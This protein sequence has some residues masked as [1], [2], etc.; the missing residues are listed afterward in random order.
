MPPDDVHLD[1]D[2]RARIARLEAELSRLIEGRD[3]AADGDE[4]SDGHHHPAEAA[5]DAEY[6]EK[7]LRDRLRLSEQ[8]ERL[9]AAQAAIEQGTDGVCV[10]CGSAISPGRLKAVPDAVRCVDCQRTVARRR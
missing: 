3:L 1:E 5:T 2:P 9:R 7:L 10:D 4:R 6:R 8:L